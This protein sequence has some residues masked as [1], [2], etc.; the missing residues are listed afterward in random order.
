MESTKKKLKLDWLHY[1]LLVLLVTLSVPTILVS[2]F[3]DTPTTEELIQQ[4]KDL[5]VMTLY[6]PCEL[7]NAVENEKYDYDNLSDTIKEL[8][9]VV[10]D[11]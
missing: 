7:L 4:G 9:A 1:L 5:E 10:D 8:L 11:C 2:Y 3:E 6:S